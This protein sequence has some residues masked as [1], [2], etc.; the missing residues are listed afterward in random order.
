VL[1]NANVEP[2]ALKPSL[3]LFREAAHFPT[4]SDVVQPTISGLVNQ[5]PA[6][7]T[8]PRTFLMP[9]LYIAQREGQNV[10]GSCKK[11]SKVG[12]GSIV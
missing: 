2:A 1:Y 10:T 7:A 9:L 4:D 3:A 6:D 11:S 8:F 12:P 5:L